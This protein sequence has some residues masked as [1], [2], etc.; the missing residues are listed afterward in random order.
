MPK[1]KWYN[2]KVKYQ[3]KS[4]TKVKESYLFLILDSWIRSKAT[5]TE[6]FTTWKTHYTSPTPIISW[7]Q[8]SFKYDDVVLAKIEKPV[9]YD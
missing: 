3:E 6:H 1:R 5:V 4:K 8:W 9:A 2:C 7:S